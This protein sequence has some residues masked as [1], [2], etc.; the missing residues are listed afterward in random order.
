MT[1]LITC[2]LQAIHVNSG[3]RVCVVTDL[4]SQV[5]FGTLGCK[6]L[7]FLGNHLVVYANWILI[8]LAIER[9]VAVWEPLRISRTWTPHHAAVS[10]FVVCLVAAVLTSPLLVMVI[11]KPETNSCSV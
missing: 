5:V 7:Y 1:F 10:L 2:H 9:F 11:Y 3:M 4:S 6:F 8:A